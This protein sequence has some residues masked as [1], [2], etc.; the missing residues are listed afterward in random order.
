VDWYEFTSVS[1]VCTVSIIREMSALTMAVN[2]PEA[3]STLEST[4]L[5][6]TTIQKTA[7]FNVF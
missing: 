2:T 4:I 3:A 7:I 6:S 1:E 5:H